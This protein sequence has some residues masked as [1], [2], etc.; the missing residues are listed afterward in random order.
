MLILPNV[1]YGIHPD[2]ENVNKQIY[3]S[4]VFNDL[5]YPKVCNYDKWTIATKQ[6]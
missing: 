3:T 4:N 2:M 6:P 5:F 1:T